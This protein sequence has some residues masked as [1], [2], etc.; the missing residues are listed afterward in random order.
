MVKSINKGNPPV[1]TETIHIKGMHCNNCVNLI[2][3][4]V[5]ALKGVKSVK[6]DLIENTAVVRFN[7]AKISLDTI[8]STIVTVGYTV[9]GDSEKSKN[10]LLQ[11]IVYGLV[12]HTGCIAFIV[13]SIVGATTAMN[14]FKPLLMNPYFFHILIVISLVFATV[15]SVVYLR[16][17]RILSLPGVKRKWRYLSVMYSSTVGINL[18]FFMVIFPLLANVS[19]AQSTGISFGGTISSV[20][21][22]VDI[23]CPGHA[24]LI[25]EELKTIQGISGIQ[26]QFPNIFE[27]KYDHTETSKEEML[28]LDVFSVYKAAVIN[29][30]SY[31]MVEYPQKEVE[32]PDIPPSL[33]EI[34]IPLSDITGTAQWYT[35]E[36]GGV[37]IQFFVVKAEDGSVKTAFDACDI[38]YRSKKGYSQDNLFMVCNNCGLTYAITSLGTMNKNPGGCWPAYLPHFSEGEDVIIKKE[39]LEKGRWM[40]V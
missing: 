22:Q 31:Q 14:V 34:R 7:P 11:G 24:P 19:A 12:P 26:F 20:T 6:A 17:N 35:Y 36:S 2:E 9:N 40:F 1:I 39:D 28:S 10:S 29:E 15:S 5:G 3:S 16:K 33:G 18:L 30:L 23:P 25:S 4:E 8:K 27:V 21:L 13:A 37:V 32:K 38:C